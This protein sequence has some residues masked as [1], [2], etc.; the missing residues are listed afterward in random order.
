MKNC[1]D[2]FIYLKGSCT[3]VWWYLNNVETC[4]F[5][6]LRVK[7][8]ILNFTYRLSAVRI[9]K[10]FTLKNHTF[11]HYHFIAPLINNIYFRKYMKIYVSIALYIAHENS[12]FSFLS[13]IYRSWKFSF[14]FSVLIDH[15]SPVKINKIF[16]FT[17]HIFYYDN[18]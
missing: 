15:L 11:L 6:L 17:N 2:A 9:D 18:L 8:I 12:H 13:I 1:R 14:F 4:F 16:V 10:M 3:L 7:I 5:I